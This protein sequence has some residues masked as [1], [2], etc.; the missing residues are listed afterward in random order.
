M[1][2]HKIPL[3]S[4]KYVGDVHSSGNFIYDTTSEVLRPKEKLFYKDKVIEI[5]KVIGDK[6]LYK[7]FYNIEKKN[8]KYLYKENPIILKEFEKEVRSTDTEINKNK[9]VS[10]E[11]INTINFN[12]KKSTELERVEDISINIEVDRNLLEIRGTQLN[13]NNTVVNLSIDKDNL[14]LNKSESIYTDRI[15]KKEIFKDKSIENLKLEKNISLEKYNNNY[16]DRTSFKEIDMNELKFIKRNRCKSIDK[17][18][19]FFVDRFNSK[20][21]V[22]NDL[23]ILKKSTIK[24][25]NV[26]RNIRGLD[27]INIKVIDKNY[28]ARLMYRSLLKNIEKYEYVDSLDKINIKFIDKYNN[29]IYFNRQNNKTLY[30]NDNKCLDRKVITTILKEDKKYLDYVPLIDIYKEIEKDLLDLTIWNVHKEHDKNLKGT[31]IKDIYKVRNNIKFIEVTKRWWWL[32][33]T[34]PTDKL[35]IPNKDFSYSTD[36]LNNAN[37]EYLRF[38]DFPIPWGMNWG[39]DYNIP[40]MKVS[41]EIMLDLLNIL[42]MMWHKNTQAWLSCTGKESMQFI[43]EL[44]YDWYTMD[45]SSLNTDYI[46]SYR[47]I[48]WESEKIYF[49]NTENGLEAIGLLIAN[50]ID[51]LK[52]HHFNLVPV[53][54]NP[55]AMDIEREFNKVATNGDIMKDLDKLK[56]KRNYM[57]EIQNFENKDTFGR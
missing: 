37:Y 30:K 14:H 35:I 8:N 9:N 18:I 20:E 16:L 53:W 33:P 54:H 28:N 4:F 5:D 41:I 23:K 43:M 32:K 25:I 49:L 3:C 15:A 45:T 7:H 13:K 55:K 39:I 29:K 36:L 22:E 44:L 34:N 27:L 2:L 31:I 56:G 52:Q 6:L 42:I 21:I 51:Y 12:K 17:D 57:V 1:P 11:D 26:Y 24:N 19:C 46:R 38:D 48:R 47:W 10:V 50:L 40:P